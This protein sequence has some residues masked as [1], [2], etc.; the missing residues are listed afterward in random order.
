MSAPVHDSQAIEKI[1][2]NVC[3]RCNK[4]EKNPH[5]KKEIKPGKQI[6]KS[7]MAL[8]LSFCLSSIDKGVKKK[9]IFF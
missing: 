4:P 3:R 1:N 7:I 8:I 5:N 9:E 6:R 2:I